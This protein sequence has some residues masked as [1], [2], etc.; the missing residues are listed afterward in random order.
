VGEVVRPKVVISRCIEY[1]SVRW[2][3]QIIRSEFVE[4]LIPHIEAITV[5][6]EVGIGL[7]VPRETLRLVKI[8]DEARLLQPRTEEDYTERILEFIDEFLSDLPEVDGYILK[9]RSPTSGLRGVK[10][11]PSI[12]KVPHIE[13]GSGIFGGVVRERF[14]HLALEDEGRLRNGRIRE[15]FL[16]K[17]Y[18]LARFREARSRGTFQSLLSF[19]TENKLLLKAYR[20]K[21]VREM[22]RI[23][24]NKEQLPPASL[25]DAYGSLLYSALRRPPR[26]GTYVNV[27]MNSLGYFSKKITGGENQFFLDSLNKYRDGKIPLI[28]PVDIMRSWIVRFDEEYLAQQSF[29]NPYPN[30]LLDVNSIVKACGGRDYWEDETP[31]ASM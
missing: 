3:A 27:L 6:P 9:S 18:T 16:R 5:C 31:Q 23:V 4:A 8:G 19:H 17:L 29:F 28:V 12:G 10:I 14:G 13:R 20:E 11:Y 15:H 2:N 22:G 24:A 30:E 1:E 21:N 25:F 26:C 7:G